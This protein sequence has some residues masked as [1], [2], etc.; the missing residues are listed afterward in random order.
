MSDKLNQ[1]HLAQMLQAVERSYH[2][3]DLKTADVYCLGLCQNLL[4]GYP[5]IP[6]TGASLRPFC[7]VHMINDILV[8]DRKDIV[9]FGSGISTLV[10]GRLIRKNKLPYGITSIEHDW[11]WFLKLRKLLESE[12]LDEIVKLVYAPLKKCSIAADRQSDWYDMETL[13]AA[14]AGKKYDM[15]IID[16][17]PAWE[18]SRR[19]A[20]YPAVPFMIERMKE[21]FSIYLDDAN[22][23]GEQSIIDL[24]QKDFSLKFTLTGK[25]LAYSYNGQSFFTEPLK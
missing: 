11:D 4:N 19:T 6:F 10:F 15:L 22:R 17:P 9:E 5:F 25:T 3:V 21:N 12:H 14:V 18:E 16:G 23:P 2:S 24:W 1:E 7:L 13:A 20:R 8:N